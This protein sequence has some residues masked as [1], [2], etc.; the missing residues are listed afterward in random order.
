MLVSDRTLCPLDRLPAVVAEVVRRGVDA[1]Q[2]REKDLPAD[3]LLAV[4]RELRAVTRG[5]ALLFVNGRV[6]VAVAAGADGVQLGER[7][8]RSQRQSALLI[9][10]SVHGVASAEAAARDGADLLVLGTIF[11]SRSHPGGATGGPELVGAVR[12]RVALPMVAIGGITVSNASAPIAAGA[13]GVAVISAILAA[14]HPGDAAAALR[15]AVD[16]AL[17]SA[18]AP[19]GADVRRPEGAAGHDSGHGER[20]S[21]GV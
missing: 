8:G 12:A 20:P 19:D 7:E 4:A 15:A 17:S 6:D 11:P 10:R 9:G 21:V 13:C 14:P 2:L 18:H 5:R 16:A 1:V 3:A